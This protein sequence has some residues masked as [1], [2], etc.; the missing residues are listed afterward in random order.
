MTMCGSETLT[1]KFRTIKKEKKKPGLK[2]N[3]QETHRV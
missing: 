1:I 3:G 2:D